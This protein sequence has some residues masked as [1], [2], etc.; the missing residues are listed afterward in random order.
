VVEERSIAMIAGGLSPQHPRLVLIA[1]LTALAIAVF[2]VTPRSR[3]GIAPEA[4][5]ETK[6]AADRHCVR[7]LAGPPW[8]GDAPP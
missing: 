5:P 7:A 1:S 2:F 6:P 8:L 4:K 3:C